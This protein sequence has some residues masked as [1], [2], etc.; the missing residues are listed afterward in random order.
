MIINLK[1]KNHCTRLI[2]TRPAKIVRMLLKVG[3]P[4]HNLHN[5]GFSKVNL[6]GK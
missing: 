5:F 2:K 3:S 6:Q 1:E 4:V